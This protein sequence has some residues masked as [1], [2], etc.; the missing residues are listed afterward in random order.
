M[1]CG[2]SSYPCRSTPPSTETA[3]GG[4]CHELPLGWH[5]PGGPVHRRTAGYGE[6]R[7]RRVPRAASGSR[8]RGRLYP[9][10]LRPIG[11]RT[12]GGTPFFRPPLPRFGEKDL[13][14]H[15]ALA[16]F[17]QTTEVGV[18]HAPDWLSVRLRRQAEPALMLPDEQDPVAR[19]RPPAWFSLR[20]EGVQVRFAFT[21]VPSG[22]GSRAI[23]RL[24][25]PSYA[26]RPIRW[27]SPRSSAA[28]GATEPDCQWRNGPAP[29][30]RGRRRRKSTQGSIS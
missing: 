19:A 21:V 8:D 13:L 28:P 18:G 12:Y 25:V 1:A 29:P 24:K 5:P 6:T 16:V 30:S 22:T 9:V 23:P 17:T 3:G 10:T 26:P 27:I 4:H 2:S 14:R 20:L 15:L 11:V 7:G